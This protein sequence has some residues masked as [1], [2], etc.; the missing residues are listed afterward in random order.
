[1]SE[2]TAPPPPGPPPAGPPYGPPMA[3]PPSGGP[4]ATGGGLP[5]ER[6]K[7]A[8]NLIETVKA[9]VTDPKGSYERAREKGDYASPVIFAVILGFIGVFFQQIWSL[10]FGTAWMT[11]LPAEIRDQYG[12]MMAA[13][14][15]GGAIF[16]I[17]LGPIFVLIGLFIWSGIVH[18]M[19]M[20]LGIAKESTAGFEGTLRAISYGSVSNLAYVIPFVGGLAAFVW[21]ITLYVIGLVR[22]HR[23]TTGKA[24]AAVLLPLLLCC[25]CVII[26]IVVMGASIAAMFANQ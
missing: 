5:W 20:L 12:G 10:V 19:C 3:P 21:G 17:I 1:M 15:V 2:P 25:V 22:M 9:M 11:V 14:G 13:Q 8:N 16:A 24:V 18:L 26:L 23:T 4:P 6:A 7:N